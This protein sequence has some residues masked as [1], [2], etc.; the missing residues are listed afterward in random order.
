[1]KESIIVLTQIDN[2][3]P[4]QPNN[5]SCRR[6]VP[7]APLP[8]CA[9]LLAKFTVLKDAQRNLWLT[10]LISFSFTRRTSRHEQDDV[11]W[12]VEGTSAFQRPGGDIVGWVWAPAMT[13]FTL[14]AG[15]LTDAIGLRRTFFPWP[16]PSARSR[17]A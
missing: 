6:T 8:A 2:L 1:V 9:V 16:S 3:W 13:V 12:P 11:L 7:L 5:R 14:L 4:T 15:S 10:F 17:A